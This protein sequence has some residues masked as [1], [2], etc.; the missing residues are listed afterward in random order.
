M[1]RYIDAD[2]FDKVLSDAQDKCKKSGGNFRYGV[3]ST[4]RGNMLKQPT[5]NAVPLDKLCELLAEANHVV[6]CKICEYCDTY[7]C[8]IF[9][10]PSTAEDWQ[11]ALTKWMEKQD[12][13]D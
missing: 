11:N 4:V 2:A 7:D 13:A 5:V 9:P 12:A 10:C 1:P 8:E 6:P 3:L